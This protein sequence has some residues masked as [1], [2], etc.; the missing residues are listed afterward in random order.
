MENKY[1]NCFNYIIKLNNVDLFLGSSP[2][3]I[4][5]IKKGDIT[6]TALAGTST[7]KNNL[8]NNKEINEHSYVVKHIKNILSKYGNKIRQEKTET[9]KLNYAYHLQTKL[10]HNYCL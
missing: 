9:L 3:K 7:E 2:E 10:H 1:K 5:E 4:I 8:K 6:S